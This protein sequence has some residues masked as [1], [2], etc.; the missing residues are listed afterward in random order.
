M[1]C[2][3]RLKKIKEP[4]MKKKV[5]VSMMVPSEWKDIP[6]ATTSQD[7]YMVEEPKH[8]YF[9]AFFR[10]VKYALYFHTEDLSTTSYPDIH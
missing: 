9:A 6:P 3:I 7:V 5:V 2:P 8:I 1:T 4:H 10:L